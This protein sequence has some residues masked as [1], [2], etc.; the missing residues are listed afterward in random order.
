MPSRATARCSCQ[1]PRFDVDLY[2]RVWVPDCF[3]FSVSVI[4][5][6][7]NDITRF[8]QYDNVDSAGPESANPVPEIP[9][10]WVHSVQVS[11]NFIYMADVINHRVVVCKYVAAVEEMLGL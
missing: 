3:R 11:D 8:G 5:N 9:M 4:D 10:A 1:I 2:G 7:A 6:N